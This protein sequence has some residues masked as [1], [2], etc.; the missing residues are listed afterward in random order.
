MSSAIEISFCI[1]SIFF[2]SLYNLSLLSLDNKSLNLS[3][4]FPPQK[5]ET[6]GYFLPWASGA[7]TL[8]VCV[9]LHL[10]HFISISTSDPFMRFSRFLPQGLFLIVPMHLIFTK[11]I[12]PLMSFSISY[13]YSFLSLLIFLS[14]Y[15][16]IYLFHFLLLHFVFFPV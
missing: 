9:S 1:C 16:I 14:S 7:S 8:Y 2:V 11:C 4:F 15:S 3:I 5:S 12:P 10:G 6:Q 13:N